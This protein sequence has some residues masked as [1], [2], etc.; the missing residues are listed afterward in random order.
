M[1]VTAD[2]GRMYEA[3]LYSM[4]YRV[5][6]WVDIICVYFLSKCFN[7]WGL[8]GRGFFNFLVFA[9]NKICITLGRTGFSCR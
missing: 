3:W 7:L 4:L 2:V 5:I 8:Q 6:F 9:D 1:V